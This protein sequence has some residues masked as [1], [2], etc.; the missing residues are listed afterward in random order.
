MEAQPTQPVTKTANMKRK[1]NGCP[2]NLRSLQ[3]ATMSI[4]TAQP[5]VEVVKL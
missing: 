2:R 1:A 4:L 3:L 5:S